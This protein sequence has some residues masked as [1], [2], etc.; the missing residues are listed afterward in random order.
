MD[1]KRGCLIALGWQLRNWTFVR[2]RR[3]DHTLHA[4]RRIFRGCSA[5][6]NDCGKVAT[7]PTE[8]EDRE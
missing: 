4:T 3:C 8:R 1:P 5:E 7:F 2:K 6:L